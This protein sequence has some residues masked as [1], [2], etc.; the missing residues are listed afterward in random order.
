MPSPRQLGTPLL[1]LDMNGLP[2]C[3]CQSASPQRL[4]AEPS[5]IYSTSRLSPMRHHQAASQCTCC[6][7]VDLDV[8]WLTLSAPCSRD[9]AAA[10]CAYVSAAS[11]ASPAAVCPRFSADSCGRAA[12]ATAN[13][14]SCSNTMCVVASEIHDPL[15]I[16]NWSASQCTNLSG[17]VV[18]I[19]SGLATTTC[20]FVAAWLSTQTR[21]TLSL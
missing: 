7:D 1:L 3:R 4:T 18:H 8:D 11:V 19:S 16:V 9:Q 10:L 13:G 6:S 20:D 14:A 2:S 15:R 12:S 21:Y 5:Y 17:L